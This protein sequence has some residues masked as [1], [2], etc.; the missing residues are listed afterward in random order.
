M[1]SISFFS[2]SVIFKSSNNLKFTVIF[3]NISSSFLFGPYLL[4]SFIFFSFFD[5]NI[6]PKYFLISEYI[7]LIDCLLFCSKLSKIF[8]S[9]DKFSSLNNNKS[10]INI[11]ISLNLSL[12]ISSNFLINNIIF[13][14]NLFSY[15]YALF[16]RLIISY[17]LLKFVYIGSLIS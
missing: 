6:E 13:S 7:S 3:K 14:T 9:F 5:F 4:N 16:I 1:N 2:S 12:F 10:F 17:K 11:I 8:S 15:L